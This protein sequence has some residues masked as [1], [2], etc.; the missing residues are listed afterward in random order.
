[1]PHSAPHRSLDVAILGTRGIPACYGGFETFAEE[2]SVRLIEKGHRVTVYGRPNYVDP[3]LALY[4]GVRISVLPCWHHKYL[5]TLTHTA[6]STAVALFKPH[7]VVLVCNAANAALCWIPRLAGQKVA[8]N[9]DGIERLRKKWNW[10]GRLFYGLSEYLAT[11]LPDAAVSDA[12]AIQEY[13]LREHGAKTVFI[14]YGA[15]AERLSENKAVREMGLDP[16]RF[17]LYVSRLEPENNAHLV[18]DAYLESGLEL[19]LVLVGDAPYNARYIKAL[20]ERAA[21]GNVIMP[22]GIYGEPYRQLLSHCLCF[23][24][25]TEVGGTHPALLEAMG[26]G[27]LVVANDTV[28]NREVVGDT[29]LLYPFNDARGL[30]R[31]LQSV[32]GGPERYGQLGIRAQC[33]V[34]QHYSWDGVVGR[35]EELFYELVEDGAV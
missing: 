1:M 2:L 20:K 14:P 13:Y 4:R 27:C 22:G 25:A 28:E 30:G 19:P 21:L 16:G 9:V 5:E 15:P 26:A 29:G 3:R 10:L 12:R 8:L 24:Q 17:L 11:E 7:D 35:Y 18:I 34:A 6:V 31:L 33:R 32:C 23:L